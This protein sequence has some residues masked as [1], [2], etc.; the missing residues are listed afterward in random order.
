[1]RQAAQ[2]AL[3]LVAVYAGLIWLAPLLFLNW[4]FVLPILLAPVAWYVIFD[5]HREI[6]HFEP[7]LLELRTLR[8]AIAELKV[9][10]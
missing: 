6:D 1:M 4:P 9:R 5:R 8:N 3:A 2:F 10:S 7:L